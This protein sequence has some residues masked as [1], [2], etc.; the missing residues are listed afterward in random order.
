MSLTAPPLSAAEVPQRAGLRF[1]GLRVTE[2]RRETPSAVSVAFEVPAELRDVFAFRPGQYLTL[3]TRI[4]GEEVRRCYS[5]CV[6]PGAGEL[7]V[8]I[9]HVEGGAFSTHANR[10]LAAG[11]VLDVLPPEGRFAADAGSADAAPTKARRHLAIAAGSGITPIVSILATLLEREPAS[12]ALLLYGSRATPEIL[13]RDALED[14]KDRHLARLAIVHVLSREEQDLGVFAG[15]L[16]GA[17]IARLVRGWAAPAAIDAAYVCGPEGLI[18]TA[19]TTLG[20][21]GVPRRH[22]HVERF[23][24]A[25]EPVRAAARLAAADA[26]AP[27]FARARVIHDGK[28][29][30]VPIAEGE[31]VLEAALRAGLDL[32][33]SCRAGMCCTCRARLVEGAAEMRQN[34]SLEPWEMEAGF[35]LTCQAVPTS[36]RLTVDYDAT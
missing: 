18:A 21:L 29:T 33:W 4:E 34:F 15:R 9:K 23:V 2:V 10:T 6:P 20:E 13:F 5:I 14:L 22:V 28:T 19:E 3:R 36:T 24:L 30:E 16:D 8:A 26:D 25:G 27:A 12:E 7:R 32:P 17:R 35:V 11:D 31:A 1:H